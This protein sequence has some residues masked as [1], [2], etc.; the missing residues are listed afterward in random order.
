METPE[1]PASVQKWYPPDLPFVTLAAGVR[2]AIT[3][4]C[5]LLEQYAQL[6]PEAQAEFDRL[7]PAIRDAYEAER[8]RSVAKVGQ[9]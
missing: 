3:N 8:D 2:D 7:V 6:P 4:C 1:R 9:A 5:A